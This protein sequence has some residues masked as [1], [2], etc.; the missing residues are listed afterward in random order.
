MKNHLNHTGLY[1]DLYQLTMAQGYFLSG[2]HTQQAT[3]DY[4]FR[5][6]PYE[7]GYV[8][9]AG[10]QDLLDLLQDFKY[11]EE[12]INYLREEGFNKDFLSYLKHFR[13]QG[14]LYSVREGEIVFP[15]EPL[16]VSRGNLIETQLI[17]TLLLN[18]INIQSLIATKASRIR[19]VAGDRTFMDFGMRRAQGLGTIWASRAAYIGGTNATS[20]VLSG[21]LYGI[22]LSG[23]QAHS[24][25]ES[26]DSEL[27]AFRIFAETATG[28]VILLVDT[29]DTL[30]SGVPNAIKIAREMK[31][32]GR[33][34][35]GIRLDSGDLANFAQKSR[36]LLDNAG[37]QKIKIIASNQLDEYVIRS[38][39]EQGAP[40]DG[41]G[42]G[43]ELITGR[44]S[45]AL[46]GVY[47]M[48]YCNG[49]PK[50][51][52][53]EN[54]EKITLPGNKKLYRILDKNG[55]FYR[56]AILL[57][58]E[59]LPDR[60]YHTLF[61]DK[62]TAITGLHGESIHE[63][64]M[65]KGETTCP[66]KSLEEIKAFALK[67]F[68]QLPDVHKR[69][70]NPH[71]YKVGISKKLLALRDQKINENKIGKN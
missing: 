57:S 22:P 38:L 34:V 56:D 9:F 44:P 29:Y 59:E 17:E 70:E 5:K 1:T 41:F 60:I 54:I 39:N 68:E 42:V 71:E 36:N 62:Q 65:E 52:L 67:R 31:E 6:N 12:D 48:S 24:W 51:K 23:T 47:K 7:G 26:F 40:V 27:E 63:K 25:I 19:K 35:D 61:H 15:N 14:T 32:K 43:T 28:K 30:M 16:I 4:F 21:K 20:N 45:A 49:D 3:F 64:V 58:D 2:K 8:L 18:V 11:S 10:L 66:Q 53:S 13:Y 69:F 37:F 55:N 50:I 46:D 33:K